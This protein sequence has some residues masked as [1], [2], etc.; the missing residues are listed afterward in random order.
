MRARLWAACT[1]AVFVGLAPVEGLRHGEGGLAGGGRAQRA[2]RALGEK[3]PL[4][5]V[6]LDDINLS[7]D[8][9][10]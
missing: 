1:A 10:H 5:G 6:A 9:A 2:R 4:L 7:G 3:S 8:L